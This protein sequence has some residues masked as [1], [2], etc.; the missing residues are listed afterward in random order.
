MF[1]FHIGGRA[2]S[3]TLQLWGSKQGTKRVQ[4]S[5]AAVAAGLRRWKGSSARVDTR[6]GMHRDIRGLETGVAWSQ[7]RWEMQR[8]LIGCCATCSLTRKKDP[9]AERVCWLYWEQVKL[10][11][12]DG[13]RMR[14]SGQASSTMGGQAVHYFL[15]FQILDRRSAGGEG[16]NS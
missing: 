8:G 15:H 2:K 9:P 4:L 7:T 13:C 6:R 16:G 14:S 5:S 11:H 1:G 10:M 3:C 12:K